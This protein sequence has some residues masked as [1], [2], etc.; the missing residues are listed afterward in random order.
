MTT[1]WPREPLGSTI[2]QRKEF[3]QITDFDQYK[4]CRVQ[5]HA[6]GI[7]LRDTVSGTEIKTKKQQ[8][9]KAGDFLVAEIDAKIGGFGIVPDDLDGAIVSSHYFLFGVNEQKLDLRFL[10]FFI[11]TPEFKDQVVAQG[12]TNYAAIRPADVLEYKVPLPRLPEQRKIVARIEELA[13]KINEARGLRELAAQERESIIGSAMN[14]HFNFVDAKSKVGDYARVQGG[15]AF[16]ST[17]YDEFGSHQVLRIG[18]VR[19][20]FLDL[21]R[22]PV[23]WSPNGDTRITK[24]E[25]NPDDLVISMTGT[26]NKRDYGFVARIPPAENLLLNQRVGRFILRREIY[27]DY[28]F[29]FL[30]SPFFRDN[31][32]PSATGTANQANVGNSDIENVPFAPPGDLSEQRQIVAELDSLQKHLNTVKKLQAETAAELHALLP[33]ILDKAFKG[34]L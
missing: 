1:S 31:L 32:F 10:D 5:L 6:Q 27:S 30:R 2:Q 3:I 4:R 16:P 24:Y 7:V 11:R 25:L 12:S 19:D 23:R 34:E 18:N 21:S 29:Y 17:Q 20:G 13:A 28:L 14:S 26:R 15:Y 22:A 33:S 9:C 8:V